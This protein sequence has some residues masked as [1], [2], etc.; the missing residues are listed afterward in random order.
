M[1]E[2]CVRTCN[3][4]GELTAEEGDS[5]TIHCENPEAFE[6]Q[7]AIECCANWTNFEWLR[8]DGGLIVECLESAV[9]A[10]RVTE[11]QS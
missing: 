1:S 11:K 8:F 2:I 9:A 3:A 10:K 7:R 5:V 6:R 4:I